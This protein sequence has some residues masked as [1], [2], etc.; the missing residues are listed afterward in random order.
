MQVGAN[1]MVGT[2]F[3]RSPAVAE[4]RY[5]REGISGEGRLTVGQTW[6]PEMKGR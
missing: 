6:Q 2:G 3:S 4:Q 1:Q 5:G